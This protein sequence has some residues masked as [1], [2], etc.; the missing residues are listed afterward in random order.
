MANLD[1]IR[2]PAGQGIRYPCR[3][4][5]MLFGVSR[6]R[7]TAAVETIIVDT[8]YA[9]SLSNVSR[10]GKY[11]SLR[12]EVVVDDEAARDR[13]HQALRDHADIIMVL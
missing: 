3:W 5:Y 9:L 7:M 1:P 8:D 13:L 6:E 12:L 4:E 10:N 2:D 11:R